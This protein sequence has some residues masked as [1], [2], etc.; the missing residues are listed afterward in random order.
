MLRYWPTCSIPSRQNE[1]RPVEGRRGKLTHVAADWRLLALLPIVVG[2]PTPGNDFLLEDFIQPLAGIGRGETGL[3]VVRRVA[4]GGG[5]L[6]RRVFGHHLLAG[7]RAKGTIAASDRVRHAQM[8][9]ESQDG[10]RQVDEGVHEHERREP[11]PHHRRVRRCVQAAKGLGCE[12]DGSVLKL[13]ESLLDKDVEKSGKVDP[14]FQQVP[15]PE[16]RILGS[17][18]ADPYRLTEELSVLYL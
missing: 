5:L 7:R 18:E 6:A 10:P 4:G 8:M 1:Q 17:R 12:M 13:G 9:V 16:I 14:G 11:S 2:I 3:G 15:C